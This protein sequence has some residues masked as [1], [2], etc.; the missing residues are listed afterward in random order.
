[1][2]WIC[3]EFND[4]RMASHFYNTILRLWDCCDPTC[5]LLYHIFVLLYCTFINWHKHIYLFFSIWIL[6]ISIN[7]QVFFKSAV[8]FKWLLPGTLQL[9]ACQVHKKHTQWIMAY[10]I[11]FVENWNVSIC[12]HCLQNIAPVINNMVS[13]LSKLA[14]FMN[15]N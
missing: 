2:C 1:M 15:T 3:S 13:L 10:P 5:S 7:H 6:L 14:W 12:R 11:S 4:P 8:H 9:S